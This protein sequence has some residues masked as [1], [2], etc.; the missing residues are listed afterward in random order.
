MAGF[1][2]TCGTCGRVFSPKA[3][4]NLYDRTSRCYVCSQCLSRTSIKSAAYKPRG[5][6][7]SVLRIGFGALFIL[8]A[9]S[10]IGDGDGVWLTC[11]IIGLGLLLWQFWP[12]LWGAVLQKR[13]HAEVLRLLEEYKSHE[14]ERTARELSR[15][16]VCS[17]CGATTSGRVCEYCGMPA[18]G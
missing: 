9:F 4:R 16:W 1:T 7:G 2:V 6:V 15:K 3:E 14:A 12:R 17:H 18:E 11:L 8:T 13:N 10:S 5:K